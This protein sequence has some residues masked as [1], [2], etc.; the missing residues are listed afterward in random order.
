MDKNPFAPGSSPSGLPSKKAT[1]V[2]SVS[3]FFLGVNYWAIV[4]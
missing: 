1:D 4:L 3:G 2:N